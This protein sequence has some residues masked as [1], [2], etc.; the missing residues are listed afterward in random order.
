MR[1]LYVELDEVSEL[2]EVSKQQYEEVL[3]IVQRHTEDTVTWLNSM[4]SEFG[5]VAELVH[6]NTT[7]ENIFS[8][9]MVRGKIGKVE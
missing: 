6:N 5:W 1:E 2:L 9:T 8:V 7:P 4:A 3:G